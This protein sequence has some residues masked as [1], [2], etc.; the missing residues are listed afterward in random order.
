MNKDTKWWVGVCVQVIGVFLAW[1]TGVAQ[2]ILD[3]DKTKITAII[4]LVWLC[5]TIIIGKKVFKARRGEIVHD[6]EF[7]DVKYMAG[8]VISLGLIGTIIGFALMY[9]GIDFSGV[10]NHNMV[11]ILFTMLDGIKTSLFTTLMGVVAFE[12]IRQQ[13]S[14]RNIH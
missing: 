1:Y 6:D 14:T 7:V 2:Y 13:L 3:A 11:P 4:L 12:C 5:A 10:N 9:A 8:F